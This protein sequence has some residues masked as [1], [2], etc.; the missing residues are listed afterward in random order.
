MK[1]AC[2]ILVRKPEKKKDHVENLSTDG[3]TILKWYF[4]KWGMG[5]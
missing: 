5:M 2:K 3:R 4:K 1:N